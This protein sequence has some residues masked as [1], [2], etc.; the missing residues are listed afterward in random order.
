MTKTR[1]SLGFPY[2]CAMALAA[3]FVWDGSCLRATW[4]EV[5]TG[6]ARSV[7][8][9][10]GMSVGQELQHWHSGKT[11]AFCSTECLERF[12][13]AP[14]EYAGA[15]H[16]T[17]ASAP[18]DLS[19]EQGVQ[20]GDP[21]PVADGAPPPMHTML[22]IPSGI[23]YSSIALV[24]LVSF[25]LFE[26]RGGRDPPKPSERGRA[27]IDLLAFGRVRR[28]LAHAWTR[29]A[30]QA[31][32]VALFGLIVVAGLF[33]N[34]DAPANL[35]PVL[36]WTIWWGGLV[37]LVLYAGKAWCYVCPWDAVAGWAQALRPLW[38]SAAHE[39]K[40]WPA[41]L[42]NVWP[43]V[44]LF[45]A[46]TWLEIGFG[47]T[48]RPYATAVLGL[49]MLGLAVGSA[50]VFERRSFCQH[51]CF[52][53]RIS[54][55]YALFASVEVRA[56]DRRRCRTCETS[57]CFHG[58]DL[59]SACPTSQHLLRMDQNTYC[60]S[61]MECVKSCEHGNVALNLRP[62][63][64]DLAHNLEARPDEAFLALVMLALTAFHGL[65]MTGAWA[66]LMGR[67]SRAAGVGEVAAFTA[68]MTAVVVAPLATYAALIAISRWS[69]G[70]RH[71]AYRE[72]FIRYAYALLP[73]A[74]FYHLAHSSEHLLLE[75][76]KVVPL[77]S[78]PL[79]R[80][81]DL[82]GTA[83]WSVPPMVRLSTLW[84][85]QVSLVLIGHVYSLWAARHIAVALFQDR[86]MARRSNLVMM[87]AMVLFSILSLWLL[88]QPMQMRTSAM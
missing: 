12:R 2:L 38:G 70:A 84:G 1:L 11:Y 56:A 47:V 31:V 54:G 27:R 55:L 53:G 18:A 73:I 71:I 26:W 78:D 72:Y 10:C 62:W 22:G 3:A 33:G 14:Q 37:I 45:V 75:G 40:P 76:P 88:R 67:I 61:C 60:T 20:V 69:S 17:N 41:A 58:N 79:G 9:V 21:V 82:L 87:A 66:E 35:A 83:R 4:R 7:D 64:E 48:H 46:L 44:V 80:G 32:V 63:G 19:P 68:G 65:T 6:T 74:L 52:V 15:T 30:M 42:R 16:G 39:G 51:A 85:V 25:G 50:L 13:R 77:M 49:L 34:Q 59:G 57:A 36:T 23:Y 5:R 24:L 81:W 43:A 8:P 28:F 86:G 29:P